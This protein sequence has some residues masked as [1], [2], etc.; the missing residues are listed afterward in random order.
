MHFNDENDCS[1]CFVVNVVYSCIETGLLVIGPYQLC[2]FFFQ[3]ENMTDEY[4]TI[5]KC[6][7]ERDVFS[8]L[9]ELFPEHMQSINLRSNQTKYSFDIKHQAKKSVIHPTS[10]T[11]KF[12]IEDTN[13]MGV[14]VVVFAEKLIFFPF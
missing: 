4:D 2:R 7:P 1:L 5:V 14:F 10:H 11:E 13:K 12:H 6:F 9:Q 3:V 8:V